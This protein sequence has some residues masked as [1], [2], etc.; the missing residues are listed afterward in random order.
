MDFQLQLRKN[1]NDYS[2]RNYEY[3]YKHLLSRVVVLMILSFWFKLV[4]TLRN[5]FLTTVSNAEGAGQPVNVSII[6]P[7]CHINEEVRRVPDGEPKS[8]PLYTNIC[9]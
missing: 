4:H 3:L 1:K 9:M 2:I 7:G 5:D 6:S 8:E